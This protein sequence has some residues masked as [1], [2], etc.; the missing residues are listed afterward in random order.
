MTGRKE[1]TGWNGTGQGVVV[2]VRAICP[3]VV[4]HPSERDTGSGGL[5]S[6][7]RKRSYGLV[8]GQ[9]FDPLALPIT[10]CCAHVLDHRRVVPQLDLATFSLEASAQRY[11]YRICQVPRYVIDARSVRRPPAS[12]G[13]TC[14]SSLHELLTARALV[15]LHL[16]TFEGQNIGDVALASPQPIQDVVLV[17]GQGSL[18]PARQRSGDRPEHVVALNQKRLA[19]LPPIGIGSQVS[20]P[21]AMVGTNHFAKLRPVL[22]LGTSAGRCRRHAGL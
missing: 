7:A 19:S 22:G 3:V 10:E 6:T 18:E 17:V 21:L 12:E 5:K 13:S 11:D 15:A 14:T 4:E 20:G 9:P 2:A 8:A 16:F 1:L